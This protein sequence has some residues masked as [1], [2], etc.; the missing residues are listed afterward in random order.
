MYNYNPYQYGYN[1]FGCGCGN[2]GYGFGNYGCCNNLFWLPLLFL[3][4]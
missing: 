1:N 2:Y 4:F 3:F